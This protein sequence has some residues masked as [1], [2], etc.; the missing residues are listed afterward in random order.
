[1]MIK[2]TYIRYRQ[3]PG[4]ISGVTTTPRS[5]QKSRES[6]RSYS[7][8]LKDLKQLNKK[9][10]KSKTV[11]KEESK[12]K[13]C[14]DMKDHHTPQTAL[15]IC[16]HPLDLDSFNNNLLINI[17]SSEILHK[18]CNVQS[19]V[20]TGLQQL[21]EFAVLMAYMLQFKLK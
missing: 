5:A 11:H 13:I 3:G 16:A 15:Q 6:L 4:G 9:H 18:K 2:T 17:Y 12:A 19:S 7:E 1:M 21:I 8:I 20:I 14:V 10:P